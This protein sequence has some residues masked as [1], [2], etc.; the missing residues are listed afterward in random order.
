[1]PR[2]IDQLARDHRNMRELLDIIEEEMSALDR[3]EAPDL[4]LLRLIMDY[5][6]NYPEAVHHPLEND[7]FARLIRRDATAQAA[8]G[9][10]L[11][12]HRRLSE[13]THRLA[14]AIGNLGRGIEMPRQLLEDTV[15]QYLDENRLHMQTEERS[16][17]PRALAVLSDE[18]WAELDAQSSG[19][20]DPLFG[21]K[22][23]T[24]YMLLHKRI[25]R[26]RV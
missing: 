22:V 10:L 7:V 18:D 17:V 5:T 12:E 11:A 25:L 20:E 24:D 1:M 8:V 21:G 19:G 2:A 14:A 3:G 6:L 13:L 26:L 15:R 16:F 4:D 23:A 9:D